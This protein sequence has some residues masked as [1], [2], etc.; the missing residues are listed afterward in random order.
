[1]WRLEAL[2]VPT[3]V[4]PFPNTLLD[5]RLHMFCDAYERGYKAVA[6]I[7]FESGSE[8]RRCQISLDKSRV[9]PMKAITTPRLELIEAVSPVHVHQII[10]KELQ[11]TLSTVCFYGCVTVHK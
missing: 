7:S 4:K 1:M 11:L 3:C 5:R 9:G 2:S 6:Y 8:S 10:R